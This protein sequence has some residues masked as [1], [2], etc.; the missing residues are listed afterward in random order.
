MNKQTSYKNKLE[1]HYTFTGW[2]YLR[3][4]ERSEL[5]HDVK[6]RHQPYVPG[7]NY[8]A[9]YRTENGKIILTSYYTD[10]LAIDIDTR[11]VQKLWK[12]YSATTMKH[13]NKFLEMF[14][15]PCMSKKDWVMMNV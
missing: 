15:L 9:T 12:G 10:V 1:E 7:C 14:G 4:E 11:E 5:Y 8:R 3:P 2:D 6:N 13:I